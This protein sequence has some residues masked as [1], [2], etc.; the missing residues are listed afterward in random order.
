VPRSTVSHPV[1]QANVTRGLS[2]AAGAIEF[3]HLRR[4]G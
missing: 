2:A 1:I 4:P 3:R